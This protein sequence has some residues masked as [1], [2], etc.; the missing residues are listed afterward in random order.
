MTKL[1]LLSA[2][3]LLASLPAWANGPQESDDGTD[4]SRPTGSAVYNTDN[5]KVYAPRDNRVNAPRDN[6]VN[7]PS[8]VRKN[9]TTN[10]TTK[11]SGTANA[12]GG[13]NTN[14]NSATAGA[15]NSHGGSSNSRGGSII[16]TPNITVQPKITILNGNNAESYAGGGAPGVVPGVVPVPVPV[17][18]PAVPVPLPAP[19]QACRPGVIGNLGLD[20]YGRPIFLNLRSG[21]S[22]QY[23]NVTGPMGE[24]VIIPDGVRVRVCARSGNWLQ[25]EVCNASICLRGWAFGQ[26]VLGL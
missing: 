1:T 18:P 19:P 8:S 9:T 7:A 20:V 22:A 3:A 14:S 10:T 21:P 26:Y 13:S 6:R 17:P 12:T 11:E 16:F 2:V 24:G 5:S 23:P 25:A 15:S 4:E